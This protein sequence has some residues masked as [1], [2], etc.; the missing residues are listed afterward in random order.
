MK[1]L[2]VSGATARSRRL[3]W[4]CTVLGFAT[5]IVFAGPPTIAEDQ[6]FDVSE[7]LPAGT[8]VGTVQASDPEGDPLLFFVAGLGSSGWN[9]LPIPFEFVP[10]TGMLRTKSMLNREHRNGWD[11]LIGVTDGEG[12]P[13]TTAAIRV[14]VLDASSPEAVIG[15]GGET[16]GEHPDYIGKEE[17][18][19]FTPINFGQ[20][21]E[22]RNVDFAMVMPAGVTFLG[23]NNEDG[24]QCGFESSVLLCSRAGIELGDFPPFQVHLLLPSTPG[25]VIHP[26]TITSG[27]YVHWDDSSV[28]EIQVWPHPAP[29]D[30]SISLGT[31]APSA[32]N[33][34]DYSYFLH[35][36][37]LGASGQPALGGVDASL[38][39]HE[40]W[41]TMSFAGTD[42]SWNCVQ[43][44][45]LA[46]CHLET[47]ARGGVAP[48]IKVTVSTPPQSS[49]VFPATA[50]ISGWPDSNTPNNVAKHATLIQR[51]PSIWDQAFDVPEF[52]P[53]G[54]R[55][56]PAQADDDM[57]PAG[58]ALTFSNNN[59]PKEV[60]FTILPDGTLEQT[61]PVAAGEKYA[62]PVRVV[63]GGGLDATAYMVFYVVNCTA[64]DLDKDSICDDVDPDDDGDS[65]NDVSDNCPLTPNPMQGDL[66]QD[67]V[68]DECDA[69]DDGD[70]TDDEHDPCPRDPADQCICSTENPDADGDGLCNG[71]DPDDDNDGIPDGSD[72]C[73]LD[74][75][76]ECDSQGEADG[77]GDS[78]PDPV[79][80]CPSVANPDQ[81][82]T[83]GDGMGD[84]CDPDDDGDGMPDA[85]DPCPLDSSNS[86]ASQ[87]GTDGDGDSVPDLTDN[88]PSVANPDQ[89]DTDGD[90]MGDACDP[91][92]DGDNLPDAA[93]PCPL[94]P[95]NACICSAQNP[96]TDGD[97]LCDSA[98][99]DDDGDGIP[100]GSDLCPLDASNACGGRIFKN[101]FE[102]A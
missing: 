76:T 83:D 62:L 6:V 32:E 95:L 88:C 54:T 84:A 77:D 19:T 70:G 3:S 74:P 34:L 73:P 97:G 27:E 5:S 78:V 58:T 38:D 11:L 24:W 55:F 86:C 25:I 4:I 53:P 18:L 40:I 60:P 43:Q 48:P 30:L 23:T 47:L 33:G 94:D 2:P 49:G 26:Y 7:N 99:G 59:P 102:A 65:V 71:T 46:R 17:V 63:D 31:S 12:A 93:D 22:T 16:Y 28:S 9:S 61:A 101:G 92:D 39:L 15:P 1:H 56:G 98:D 64:G 14:N 20:I 57:L 36:A 79:D 21:D 82:D 51:R 41:G 67:G 81:L 96:D 44:D 13:G 35:V 29:A 50:W 45:M 52:S 69:D 87:G 66:D 72:P 68:G 90:G 37:D 80:N 75:S 42:P 10:G 91:D 100:D 8:V 85:V 89:L